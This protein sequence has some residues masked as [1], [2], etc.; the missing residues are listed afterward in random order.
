MRQMIIDFCQAEGLNRVYGQK[1]AVTFKLMERMF[2]SEDEV[3]ALLEPC[4]LWP[5]VLSFDDVKIE[6]LIQD[7]TVALEIREKLQGLKQVISGL[8]RLW[9]KRLTTEE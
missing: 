2:F 8:P 6:Q 3:R 9:V 7:E 4:G 5:R 1:Y